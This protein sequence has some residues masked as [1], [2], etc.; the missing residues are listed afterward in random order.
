M[1]IFPVYEYISLT[2]NHFCLLVNELAYNLSK[3]LVITWPDTLITSKDLSSPSSF[4][5][6]RPSVHVK[7][8][9]YLPWLR[10][11][12]WQNPHLVSPILCI[13]FTVGEIPQCIVSDK[14]R[15]K[16]VSHSQSDGRS[17]FWGNKLDKFNSIFSI[18]RNYIQTTIRHS[19]SCWQK[20]AGISKQIKGLY[21]SFE[22]DYRFRILIHIGYS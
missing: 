20:N 12:L 4:I 2:V 6:S 14:E 16:Y 13:N 10:N 5:L 15:Q 22:R 1:W 17:V 11:W 3:F 18:D 7:D 9:L 19:K 21:S 8:T